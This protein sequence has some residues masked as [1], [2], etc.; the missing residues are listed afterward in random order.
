MKAPLTRKE[1]GE[2]AW[3]HFR[4][5][6]AEQLIERNMSSCFQTDRDREQEPLG[7]HPGPRF[8]A[9]RSEFLGPLGVR[10]KERA[11]GHGAYSYRLAGE[12]GMERRDGEDSGRLA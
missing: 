1:L 3:L 5:R 8:L 2:I 6:C 4:A 7:E 12:G 10:C 11:G 9:E